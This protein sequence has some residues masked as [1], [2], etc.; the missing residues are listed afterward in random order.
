MSIDSG[1]FSS[2]IKAACSFNSADADTP[3]DYLAAK[4]AAAAVFPGL[5]KSASGMLGH[6]AEVAGLGMLARPTIQEARGKEVS[7]K[8]KMVHELGG[9]GVLAAP[10]LYEM[11]AA[12]KQKLS[13]ML[14]S[15]KA[16][17]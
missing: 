5:M 3:P 14:S 10:S 15:L 9:L 7:H 6:A 2:F 17:R 12:A 1:A 8:S 4:V 13:P 11:G 16:V